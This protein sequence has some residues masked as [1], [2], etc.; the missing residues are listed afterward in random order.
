MFNEYGGN[1]PWWLND[2]LDYATAVVRLQKLVET[3][4]EEYLY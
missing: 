1:R 4:R 2:E 3:L